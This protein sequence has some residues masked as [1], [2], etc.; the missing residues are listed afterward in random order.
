[1]GHIISNNRDILWDIFWDII[2]CF[3]HIY[4]FI[5]LNGKYI[6]IYYFIIADLY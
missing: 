6:Y 3:I 4:I 1:M 2:N 5:S